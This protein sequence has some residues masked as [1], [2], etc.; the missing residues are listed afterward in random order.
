MNKATYCSD[1]LS[2][3]LLLLWELCL[4]T[5]YLR[6][7]ESSCRIQGYRTYS[8]AQAH[9]AFSIKELR[10]LMSDAMRENRS[11]QNKQHLCHLPY[12]CLR[13]LCWQRPNDLSDRKL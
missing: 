13:G 10:N 9:K 8:Y 3:L 4:S 1:I 12:L 11:T 5:I 6:E 2:Q 7:K